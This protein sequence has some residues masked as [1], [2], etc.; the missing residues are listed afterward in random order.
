MRTPYHAWV[1]YPKMF[2]ET[3][4]TRSGLIL[5]KVNDYKPEW[6]AILHGEVYSPPTKTN[7]KQEILPGDKIYFHYLA[8]D[9]EEMMT[10]PDNGRKML[11]VP[12]SS[13]FCIVRNGEIIPYGGH[14]F[15]K[16]VYSDDIQEVDVD[17]KKIMA[18]VSNSGLVTST[19]VSFIKNST[20]V[21]HIGPPLHGDD[22]GVVPGDMV[23]M[24]PNSHK[25]YEVEGEKYHIFEQS[26]ILCIISN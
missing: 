4:E 1:E 15:A 11:R 3:I 10:S 17:G 26:D 8:A 22:L 23:F 12:E 16:P 21:K 14:V 6:H 9:S 2:E 25:E 18:R 13:I 5:A 7:I 19:Q 20:I 24:E